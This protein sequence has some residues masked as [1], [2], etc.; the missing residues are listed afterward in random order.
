[1]SEKLK[2]YFKGDPIIW[3]VIIALMVFSLLAVASSTKTLAYQYRG[4]N[5]LYYWFRHASFLFI[6]FI[7]VYF[8]HLVPYRYFSR[9]SQLLFYLSIP[10]LAVTL[11]FGTSINEAVRWITIPGLGLTFQT[12]DLA[13]IVLIMFIARMLSLKQD[14]IK[15]YRQGFVPFL[16]PVIVTCGLILPANLSTAVILFAVSMV[17]L[18]IGRVRFIYLFGFSVLVVAFLIGFVVVLT[19]LDMDLGTRARTWKNRIENFTSNE[20]ADAN[21]QSDQSKIAI[22]TGGVIGRGPGNSVQ[23]DFLPHPY[24]DFIFAIIVEEYGL[25]GGFLVIFLY[26]YLLFRAGVIVGQSTRTFQAF[27]AYGLTLLLVS[28]AMVN[29]AVAVGIFPVTGQ[30][31]PLISMGGTSMLF[32]AAALGMIL[33]VSRSIDE[34]K[35]LKAQTITNAHGSEE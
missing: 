33:S 21:Y 28:Q 6:G 12:S 18:F 16:A 13:K 35:K 17:I 27:L 10:L 31:L 25:W 7:T 22:A 29:M 19:N 30:P 5:A 8:L 20:N 24:S 11:I 34:E 32:T 23:R 4:G 1:M 2:K 9:L 15:N 14:V 26:L 3:G